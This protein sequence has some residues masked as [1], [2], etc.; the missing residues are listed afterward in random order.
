LYKIRQVTIDED[1][2]DYESGFI[3]QVDINETIKFPVS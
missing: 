2:I 3:K 1:A